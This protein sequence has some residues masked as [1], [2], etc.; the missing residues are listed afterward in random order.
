MDI[1]TL[2]AAKKAARSFGSAAAG[3]AAVVGADGVLTP[4]TIAAGEVVIDDT[5]AIEGAAADAAATGA[6]IAA[7]GG[8]VTVETPAAGSTFTLDPCPV[9]YSFGERAELTLT[10]ATT[11]Q[12]HFMFAC[13]SSAATVLTMAGITKTGDTLAAGKTY[14]VDVWAGIARI[15]E[16][17]TQ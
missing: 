13:P 10:L 11:T 15:S 8:Q 1:V 12:Y 9:T 16:V 6:A 5:L 4:E 17:V 7:A 14:E 3:K 2:A